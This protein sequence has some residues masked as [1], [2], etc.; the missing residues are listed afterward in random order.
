MLANRAN[1]FSFIRRFQNANRVVQIILGLSFIATINF[2]SANY[3]KRFD[4]TKSGDYTL[5]AESKAYIRQLEKPVK[6]IV[7][8]PEKTDLEGLEDIRNDLVKLLREY[9]FFSTRYG[10][11]YVQVEFVDI[12]RQRARAQELASNYNLT[13]ENTILVVCGDKVR[14]ISIG[15]LYEYPATGIKKSTSS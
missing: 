15:D 7:T 5:A 2:L 4:L 14:Q 11:K 8:I 13:Q 12:Y 3:F 1:E 6:I 9:E 10:K